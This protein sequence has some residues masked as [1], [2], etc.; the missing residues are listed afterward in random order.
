MSDPID[1]NTARVQ[2]L[3]AEP[4]GRETKSAVHRAKGSDQRN[5][6]NR[7]HPGKRRRIVRLVGVFESSINR[8][9]EVKHLM[10]GGRIPLKVRH[11][12]PICVDEP[13]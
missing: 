6:T 11:S 1:C 9:I 3:L 12:F 2:Q 13:N 8:D 10:V 4:I 7:D 5:E